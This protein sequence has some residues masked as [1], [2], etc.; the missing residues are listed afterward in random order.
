MAFSLGQAFGGFA[1]GLAQGIQEG[2]QLAQRQEQIE[3]QKADQKLKIASA[4]ASLKK[5]PLDMRKIVAPGLMKQFEKAYGTEIPQVLKDVAI[6]GDDEMM[7]KTM[8]AAASFMMTGKG[9]LEQIKAGLK[10]LGDPAEAMAFLGKI[11]EAKSRQENLAETKRYHS[12]SLG[13]Q[14]QSLR[15][16]QEERQDRR[17]E[18]QEQQS[19]LAHRDILD[20]ASKSLTG[21]GVT[22]F[23]K[24]LTE[25]EQYRLAQRGNN[26][27]AMYAIASRIRQGLSPEMYAAKGQ[28][29][30]SV[31][32]ELRAKYADLA[33]KE[34][35]PVKK[36][37]YEDLASL[38][39]RK[40]RFGGKEIPATHLD[41]LESAST[42][43]RW[44]G[45]TAEILNDPQRANVLSPK[46]RAELAQS[47]QGLKLELATLNK[48]GANFTET[49]QKMIDA[50]MG[51]NPNDIISRGLRNRADFV[52]RLRTIHSLIESKVQSRERALIG[53]Q[54]TI[55]PFPSVKPFTTKSGLKVREK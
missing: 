2:T 43:T 8:D 27:S 17:A 38:Y 4:F 42:A 26:T 25:S 48:R 5:M 3:I 24:S 41:F 47:V 31:T 40:E 55:A 30:I 9:D 44:A 51:G 33:G 34:T 53:G 32:S 13:I 28:S 35:D 7:A 52:D 20:N 49:E 18:R 1:G 21:P 39:E 46:D 54:A 36:K 10:Q 6:K 50:I 45:K 29:D 37:K 15:L 16:Q 14:A 19:G 23:E 11:A 12:G 22:A